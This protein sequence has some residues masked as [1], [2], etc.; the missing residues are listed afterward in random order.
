MKKIICYID[1]MD[2]TGAQRVMKNIVTYLGDKNYNVILIND[3]DIGR[4]DS[5]DISNKVKRVFLRKNN[6]G[7]VF[8]KNIER[9]IRLRKLVKREKPD[10]ILSFLGRPN[11]R[12]LIATLGVNVKKIVSVRN[13]PNYEYGKGK[14]KKVLINLLFE[15]ADG[16]VFQ[17]DDAK[18]Y[19]NKKIQYNSKIILNPVDPIF[20]ESKRSENC[21]G[22]V[23][24]GR[25][26][27]QKNHRLLIRAYANLLKKDKKLEELY[28]YG[29]GELRDELE[30]IIERKNLKN[31]VHLLG[32]VK[33]V[34]KILSSSKLFVL[35]S[36]F[37]G[38]PNVLMEAMACGTP[39]ISTDC[40][41]GGP[42][43]LITN[44][45][46]GIL[47]GCNDSEGL[48]V[49]I[50]KLIYDKSALEEMSVATRNRAK[51]FESLKILKEWE[52]YLNLIG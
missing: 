41:C 42:R 43:M 9:I 1:I 38:L 26:D 33:D 6:C 22:I 48:E 52:E 49:A 19:F 34:A 8:I 3:F 39:V 18:N 47:V 29:D 15:Q 24:F 32:N 36:D 17:T 35:S 13:D 16:C 4:K 37:E 31:K 45:N 40:P 21:K 10:I 2:R 20:F 30:K 25:L 27:K 5:F 28:I 46:E 12:M 7:N 50:K 44:E 14:L 23:T 11:V 51:S